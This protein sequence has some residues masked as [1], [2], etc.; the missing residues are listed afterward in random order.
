MSVRQFFRIRGMNFKTILYLAVSIISML[1][2]TVVLFITGSQFTETIESHNQGILQSY[3][4]IIDQQMQEIPLL[5]YE[6]YTDTQ[7]QELAEAREI[8]KEQRLEVLGL[9][10][11]F[12]QLLA[13]YQMVADFYIYM[14]HSGKILTPTGFYDAVY[15]YQA[16]FRNVPEDSYEEWVERLRGLPEEGQYKTEYAELISLEEEMQSC[17][18]TRRDR[19]RGMTCVIIIDNNRLEERCIRQAVTG[20]GYVG[21]YGEYGEV[22]VEGAPGSVAYKGDIYEPGEGIRVLTQRS[23]PEYHMTL[24]LA[25]PDTI[26]TAVLWNAYMTQRNCILCMIILV[27]ISGTLFVYSYYVQ[28]KNS[29]MAWMRMRGQ[30]TRTENGNY[31]ELQDSLDRMLDAQEKEL[32]QE[33]QIG[34][35]LLGE[36]YLVGLLRKEEWDPQFREKLRTYYM[37]MPYPYVWVMICET[38][39]EDSTTLPEM[40]TLL[41]HNIMTAFTWICLNG[42]E[43]QKIVLLN[44]E[45]ALE[46]TRRRQI[47]DKLSG[48]VQEKEP[49]TLCITV[50]QV[51]ETGRIAEAYENVEKAAGYH[52]MYPGVS[53]LDV[54]VLSRHAEKYV[55]TQEM[56][57][58]LIEAATEQ[59]TDVVIDILHRIFVRNF[60]KNAIELRFAKLLL[61]ALLNTVYKVEALQKREERQVYQIP[62]DRL[63]MSCRDIDEAKE[64]IEFIFRSLCV[65]T[66][67][68]MTQETSWRMKRIL[69]YIEDHYL[70]NDLS[71]EQVADHFRIT[72]QYLSGLFKK[73]VSQ[74][75]L[76]YLT[77][78]RLENA[79][80]LMSGTRLTLAEIAIRS[81]FT[82]YLALARAFQKYEDQ[83]PGEYRRNH[84]K[85]P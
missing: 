11:S 64:Q 28:P 75:F 31:R 57:N 35:R 16:K 3:E 21:I 6:L 66:E 25:M 40:E 71:L 84:V 67:D 44:L 15:Y 78:L 46:E 4:S 23:L 33:R 54:S 27:G 32:R 18:Y 7:I 83:T 47:E 14:D 22:L 63:I 50:G 74:N 9:L 12:P 52:F 69:R 10:D 82:N 62:P 8:T 30:K 49:S 70:E 68:A 55:Y 41:R 81:G 19:E 20:E 24:T 85:R 72:P 76:V 45:G 39:I 38:G 77:R 58:A 5:T 1:C 34:R 37:D 17:L 42:D 56:E 26:F 61:Y 43:R 53:V 60:E 13:G 2:G 80:S 73:N 48:W 59:Q 79:K 29:L 65:K 36:N 51:V